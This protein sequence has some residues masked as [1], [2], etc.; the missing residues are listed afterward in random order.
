MVPRVFKTLVPVTSWKVGSIPM[1][2]RHIPLL[3]PLAPLFAVCHNRAMLIL[4][5]GDENPRERTPYVNYVIL[6]LNVIVFLLYC[7]PSPSETLLVSRA[8]IP[9]QV[10][11]GDPSTWGTM[12]TSMFLHADIFH[13]LGNL[14][15]LWICGDNVEDK[16]GHIPY[17][18]FYLVCGLAAALLHV[19]SDPTSGIP[20]I[21][22]SGAIS[23]A[24]AAYVVF[25]PT[26]RIKMLFWIFIFV[27]VFYIPAWAWIGF[28]F[29]EQIIM[30][31]WTSNKIGG[32]VA[33]LAHIGGFIAGLGIGFFAKYVVLQNRFEFQTN[34][35]NRPRSLQGISTRNQQ[36]T[37]ETFQPFPSTDNPVD[38]R[39]VREEEFQY[40]VIRT[41]EELHTIRALAAA[42]AGITEE[43]PSV[44]SA[45]INA[46][47]GL[48]AK[49]LSREQADDVYRA[50]RRV[51]TQGLLVRYGPGAM[52]P[53]P[54][55]V[56]RISWDPARLSPTIQDQQH[57]IPWST[58]YLYLASVVC[59]EPQ[60]DVY[61]TP[62]HAFR[63]TSRAEIQEIDPQNRT[64]RRV[65]LRD[66]AE[67]VL[68]KNDHTAMNDGIRVMAG[69]GSFGWLA[70]QNPEYYEDYAFWVYTLVTTQN[71]SRWIP[72]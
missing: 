67:A 70:F 9:D 49:N 57:P 17:A 19:V 52:P 15:F 31:S 59:R 38:V 1:R 46:T 14:L 69:N 5:I 65:L 8:M 47:R 42:T 55:E 53:T 28:W 62:Q 72:Q 51:G 7:F 54:V 24:L 16:L 66:L 48:I 41:T 25:F 26:H 36:R 61:V 34:P 58:P 68:Q 32:G 33:Y 18:I 11:L 44:V 50:I 56:D 35:R 12:F 37:R 43:Q 64:E 10:S 6:T 4:P 60:L 29:L 45:R 22:A 3:P 21:G 27:Q 63:V 23:G 30:A 20:T 71:P 40:A 39:V 2:S 13:L